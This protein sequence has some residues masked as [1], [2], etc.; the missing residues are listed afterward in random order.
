[1]KHI[2]L[3]DTKP[4]LR[5]RITAKRSLNPLL[6][7]PVSVNLPLYLTENGKVVTP[8]RPDHDDSVS[9]CHGVLKRFGF[10]PP[11]M[12]RSVKR[13]FGRFVD[14]WCRKNLKPLD[15]VPDFDEWLDSTPYAASRKVELQKV[16]EDCGRQPQWRKWRKNKSFIK[17]ETYFEYKAL[18]LI[19]SRVDS[20]KCFFGP[21]VAAVSKE[22][23]KT[24]W[25][26][27]NIPVDQRPVALA[28]LVRP[29]NEY[30]YTDYTSFEAHFVAEIMQLTQLKLY[31]HMTKNLP[32]GYKSDILRFVEMHLAGL[33]RCVFNF[34]IVELMAT[35]MSGEMDTSLANGFSNLMLFLFVC[36][37]KSIPEHTVR[38]FVEGDDGIFSLPVKCNITEK[39]F[40]DLGFTI[41]IGITSKFNEASFCGQVYDIDDGIVVTDVVDSL[42]R[43]GWTNKRYVNANEKTKMQ[44]LRA[45]GFSYA[46]QYNGCP[47]LSVLGRKIIELTEGVEIEDRIIDNYDLYHKKILQTALVSLP[48]EKTPG[49]STRYLVADKFGLPIVDQLK[50]EAKIKMMKELGP[51]D[52][53]DLK[54]HPD[55]RHYSEN[56]V[57]PYQDP[58]WLR[59][60]HAKV[61]GALVLKMG[62]NLMPTK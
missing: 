13:K 12:K 47:V 49:L 27:K 23:F 25:F 55:V 31:K 10:L 15:S 26:V 50:M 58:F 3:P 21:F 32:A 33:N 46:Y 54:L 39:D 62:P 36:H 11:K 8:P 6:R 60:D 61:L 28:E 45:R 37:E 7:R 41:K 30:I 29:G 40:E 34:V 24:R 51:L 2:P 56:Y 52:V 35:R 44:L 59:R 20:A 43:L 53:S 4:D 18:R 48:D 57:L 17:D 19:N 38:G 1:M 16:W 9:L 22:V 14:L 42:M 5:M